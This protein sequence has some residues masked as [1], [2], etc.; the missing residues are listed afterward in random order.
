MRQ[1]VAAGIFLL[2]NLVAAVSMRDLSAGNARCL[3][4]G[5]GGSPAASAFLLTHK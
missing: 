4:S 1:Q 5:G 2:L 3:I